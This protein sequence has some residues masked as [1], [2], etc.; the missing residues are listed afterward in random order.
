MKALLASVL[1]IISFSSHAETGNHL[2]NWYEEFNS[3]QD[4]NPRFFNIG[5]LFGHVIGVY[6]LLKIEGKI[7]V[8][9]G[10][11][12][13]TIIDIVGQYLKDNPTERKKHASKIIYDA[14][15]PIF[16]C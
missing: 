3:T 11:S 7:C 6:E 2:Y 16:P 12:R 8:R 9:D 13:G 14:L 10:V 4:V 5:Q 1:L 15:V